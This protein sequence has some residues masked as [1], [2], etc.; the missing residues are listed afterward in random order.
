MAQEGNTELDEINKKKL[1]NLKKVTVNED[2]KPA[3]V[4]HEQLKM[5]NV[6]LQKQL[7]IAQTILLDISETLAERGTDLL[8]MSQNIKNLFKAPTGQQGQ[9]TIPPPNQPAK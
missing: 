5:L 2:P 7:N 8:N 1:E 4:S 9:K 6:S 3:A